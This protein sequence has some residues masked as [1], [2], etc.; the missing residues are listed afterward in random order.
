[1]KKL[2]FITLLMGAFSAQAQKDTK[3]GVKAGVDF[4]TVKVKVLGTTASS[5]ETGFFVGGFATLGVSDKFAVQPELL[6]VGISD[7]NFFSLP[8]LAKY[9]FAEKFSA[10]AG[11]SF[12]YFSDAEEDKFKVNID[13]G[14]TYDITENIDINAKYSLGFGDV[15]VSGVFVGAGYKF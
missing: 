14:A 6:Y 12:N 7:S 9:T 15:A 1:M 2:L 4:A 10:L 5:S 3:F 13:L 11:P 8:V